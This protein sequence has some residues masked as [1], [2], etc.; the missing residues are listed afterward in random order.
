ML[1]DVFLPLVFRWILRADFFPM[2]S[3]RKGRKSRS[4]VVY[5]YP[6][7]LSQV[8]NRQETVTMIA[9]IRSIGIFWRSIGEFKEE[10]IKIKIAGKTLPQRKR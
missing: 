8:A 10:K 7:S 2:I 4:R 1:A 9:E 6:D 5:L 3:Q